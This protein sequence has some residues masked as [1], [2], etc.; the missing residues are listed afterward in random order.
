MYYCVD[1]TT[2]KRTSLNTTGG[3]P[4]GLETSGRLL[5]EQKQNDSQSL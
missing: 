2:G 1:K 5:F 3:P 4:F